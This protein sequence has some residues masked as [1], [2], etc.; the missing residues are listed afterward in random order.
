MTREQEWT[1]F[2]KAAEVTAAA[3]RGALGGEGSQPPAFVAEVFREVHGALREAAEKIPEK[4]EKT[5]F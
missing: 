5:G 3:V 2:E 4:G 1:V